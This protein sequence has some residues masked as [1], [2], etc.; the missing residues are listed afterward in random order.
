M[1]MLKHFALFF[2]VRE[3]LKE[4]A[5]VV[6]NHSTQRVKIN[7]ELN[8]SNLGCFKASNVWL[9]DS[10]NVE[11]CFGLRQ[12]RNVGEARNVPLFIR[13]TTRLL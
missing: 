12:T 10:K 2:I 7:T 4:K 9:K 5:L 6:Q 11:K 1:L 3:I 13:L 8:D